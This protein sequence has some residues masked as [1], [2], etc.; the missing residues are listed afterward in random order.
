MGNMRQLL[1]MAENEFD[2]E[3]DSFV[4]EAVKEMVNIS[5]N[6]VDDDVSWLYFT[7]NNQEEHYELALAVKSRLEDLLSEFGVD[8]GESYRQ[9]SLAGQAILMAEAVNWAAKSIDS[10]FY[11]AK[12]SAIVSAIALGAQFWD[13]EDECGNLVTYLY[14]PEVGTASFHRAGVSHW[15]YTQYDYQHLQDE[16]PWSGWWRQDL[17]FNFLTDPQL[18]RFYAWATSP[19]EFEEDYPTQPQP[20][21]DENTQEYADWIE[22]I[23]QAYPKQWAQ[24][25]A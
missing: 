9:S 21:W 10:A 16:T 23:R 22:T 3:F 12:P 6:D 11:S 19:R 20:E 4:T 24:C 15:I 2:L 17:A 13:S 18:M 1:D 5:E 7:E 8:F 14:T 25:A